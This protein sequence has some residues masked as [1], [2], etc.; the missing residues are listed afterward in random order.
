MRKFVEDYEQEHLGIQPKRDLTEEEGEE[1]K[2]NLKS[3]GMVFLSDELEE[4]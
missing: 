2:E 1:K 3:L 4:V